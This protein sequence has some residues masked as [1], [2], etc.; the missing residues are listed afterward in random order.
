MARV[1]D[2][3]SAKLNMELMAGSISLF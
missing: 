3:L 1:K 2:V